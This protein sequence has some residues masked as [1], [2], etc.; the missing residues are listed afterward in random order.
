MPNW[1]REEGGMVAAETDG[2]EVLEVLG[3]SRMRATPVYP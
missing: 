1:W 2:I 3:P